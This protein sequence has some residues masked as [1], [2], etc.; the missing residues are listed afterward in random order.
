MHQT[1]GGTEQEF[2]RVDVLFLAASVRRAPC[3]VG[4]GRHSRSLPAPLGFAARRPLFGPYSG[5]GLNAR[6][7]LKQFEEPE[8]RPPE[9]Q[10]GD[11]VGRAHSNYYTEFQP[12][13]LC[14]KKQ[15]QVEYQKIVFF[16][17]TSF[18]CLDDG[19]AGNAS[20]S[21]HM[22]GF[23]QTT[24]LHR[25]GQSLHFIEIDLRTSRLTAQCLDH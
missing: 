16:S 8:A 6:A 19:V 22:S 5:W 17:V 11:S 13:N 4:S 10:V 9:E 3:H 14:Q 23:D 7:K 1:S 18:P 25:G 2:T 20:H 15:K 21:K 12:R 24:A